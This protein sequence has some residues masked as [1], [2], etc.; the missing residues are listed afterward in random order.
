MAKASNE[1]I[2]ALRTAAKNI[3]EGSH[4]EWGH[5][6]SCNCGHLAQVVCE[7]DKAEI[8]RRAMM[9]YG[10]WSEQLLDYCPT[11]GLPM[12]DVIDGLVEIGFSVQDLKS[13][14]RLNN[15][16]IL[17]KLSSG[18]YLSRNNRSD[19]ILYLETW[20]DMLEEELL[21]K[22]D[23]KELINSSPKMV[24]SEEMLKKSATLLNKM[25]EASF[26]S[27]MVR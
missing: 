16:E 8:H 4:Y 2:R 10:D 19:V 5:M 12:D 24:D 26:A 15:P 20:A 22:V 25:P 21:T 27:Y 13:L 1:T 18:T 7:I 3:R 9:R 11:S 14:E 17:K 23:L 6:G